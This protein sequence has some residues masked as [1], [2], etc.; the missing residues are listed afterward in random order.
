MSLSINNVL[1]LNVEYNEFESKVISFI[2][3]ALRIFREYEWFTDITDRTIIE[4]LNRVNLQN[5][6]VEEHQVEREI[7]IRIINEFD[8]SDILH[9]NWRNLGFRKFRKYYRGDRKEMKTE[10][11][12]EV[13]NYKKLLNQFKNG[14]KSRKDIEIFISENFKQCPLSTIIDMFDI[15]SRF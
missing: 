10:L 6:S 2:N 4:D 14:K 13:S 11:L 1:S 15:Y 9:D 5:L 8:Y 7:A 3:D 12:N